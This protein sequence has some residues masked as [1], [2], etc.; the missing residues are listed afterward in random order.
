MFAK[1]KITQS[2]IDAVNSV[3]GETKEEVKQ[4]QLLDEEKKQMLLEPELDETGF[5]KAAHAAKKA[6]QSHFEF[7]GKKYPVTA[8][9]HAEAL[10]MEASEKVPTPTGM[11][12]YGSSYGNSAKARRDQTK[13]SVDDVKEPTKKDIEKD[14]KLYQ[15]TYHGTSKHYLRPDTQ[16]YMSKVGEEVEVNEEGDCVTKP[17]AKDIAKKEVGK[18]EK[19]MHGKSGEVAKHVK[20]MHKESMSFANKLIASLNE[21]KSTGTEEIFTDNNLGEEEMTDAQMKKR[22]KIVMSMKKGEAGFK[23]RYGKNWKNVMYATA[24]KQAMKEDSSDEWEGE[25]LDEKRG[26]QAMKASG[27]KQS[28]DKLLARTGMNMAHKFPRK[29]QT[30]LGNIPGMNTPGVSKD[31]A[32]YAERRRADRAKELK[33]AIKSAL[34]THGPHGKLPEEVELDE[35]DTIYV[36]HSNGAPQKVKLTP[37]MKA[38]GKI[39]VQHPSGP[40]TK[41]KLPKVKEE[42]ELEKKA[43]KYDFT[44]T[45]SGKPAPKQTKPFR[46]GNE[47]IGKMKEEVELDE[48]TP[49]KGTDIADKAYLKHKPGTVKGQLTQIG[50]FLRGKPEIK[51][52]NDSH[53][54]AAHYENEKGEWTGMNL[55][56]AKDDDDAIKQAQ[57][58]C[59]EGCRLSKVERHTTVKEEVVTEAEVTTPAKDADKITTDMLRGREAGGK[60]NAF[61]SFKA[62]LKTNGEMKAPTEIDTGTD[63]KEKQKITTNPGAVDVKFDD[64]L[65]TPP[66]HYFSNEKQIANEDFRGEM[67]TVHAKSKAVHNKDIDTFNKKVTQKEE[68]ESVEEKV[69]AGTPGW[70]KIKGSDKQGNIKDKSGATHTPMS[71]ARDLAK[72]SFAKLK[73]ETMMGKISN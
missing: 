9:S 36:Q 41:V 35:A 22:E 73:N 72:K 10:A 24:T 38:A 44:K 63:T 59:K 30:N 28:P 71:R 33:P 58:K 18:H 56:T 67:K 1:G 29:G 54:H 12:V 69:I 23:Q 47:P 65:S 31:T 51:E 57:A 39:Y 3:L 43:S 32:D 55:F 37:D 14:S 42:T 21:A 25:Q 64:K 50:R 45:K 70:E 66:Q 48:A 8:K 20:S 62:H 52:A 7:Q 13:S 34:G 49:T 5:H 46:M 6:S 61:K 16:K 15:K 17:Q 26:A 53:T 40:Q 4:V 19:G 27:V 68:T 11:K 2:M 60:S